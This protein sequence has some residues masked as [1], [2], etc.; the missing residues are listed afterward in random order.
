MPWIEG[1]VESLNEVYV[2][3]DVGL[4][5]GDYLMLTPLFSALKERFKDATIYFCTELDEEIVMFENNS[6][7]DVI[8]SF[9]QFLQVYKASYKNIFSS[10]FDNVY[11]I[12]SII[13][14]SK[15]HHANAY[16]VFC[17]DL[18]ILPHS[19]LPKYTVTDT[20]QDE[21]RVLLSQHNIDV[22]NDT[23]VV[24]QT[25]ASSPL[26]NWHPDYTKSLTNMFSDDIKV[27]LLGVYYHELSEYF[28][29]K[30]NVLCLINEISVRQ[31]CAVVGEADFVISPDSLFAHVAGALSIQSLVL[32]SSFSGDCRYNLMPTVSVLQQPFDC[33]PCMLHN[34][35]CCERGIQDNLQQDSNG[36]YISM[37][38]MLSITPD[39]VYNQ[40]MSMLDI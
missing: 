23:V 39:I 30:S 2:L 26:R 36:N 1:P 7:I 25:D 35:D 10:T 6:D 37:P 27:V 15:F 28:S 34:I 29:D 19:Y 5:Y 21:A 32:M 20:E 4:S 9:S 12:P 17:D 18:G 33:A 22:D 8:M 3:C 13:M 14:D 16:Q 40:V 24:I 31:A 11:Q 38:C